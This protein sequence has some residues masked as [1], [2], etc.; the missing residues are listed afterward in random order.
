MSELA[1]FDPAGAAGPVSPA[2]AAIREAGATGSPAWIAFGPPVVEPQGWKLYVSATLLNFRPILAAVAPLFEEAGIPYKHVAGDKALRKLN[3]GLNGYSQVGKCIVAY[4]GEAE[5]VERLIAR[6]KTALEPWRDSCPDVPFARSLGGGLPL[7]YRYG[8]YRGG[9]IRVGG[10]RRADRRDGEAVPKG[11]PDP[12]ARFA[13]ADRSDEAFERFLARFPIFEAIAQG[14]KGGV[15][16]AF[17]LS[18][19]SFTEVIVKIG[20]R[21]GQVMPDGRDGAD[22]LRREHGFFMAL[23]NAGLGALAPACVAYG[24]FDRKHALVMERLPGEDLMAL[25]RRGELQPGHV[26]QCLDLLRRMHGAGL[27]AGDPKLANFVLDGGGRPRGIDFECA[28]LI[29][30]H[31]FDPLRTFRLFNPEIDDLRTLDL[32]HFLFSV[33]Y[34]SRAAASFSERDR[35]VDVAAVLARRPPEDPAAAFAL[36]EFKAL[37]S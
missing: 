24:E 28:G 1:E 35:L 7:F 22:L 18:R 19:D 33:L 23:E 21:N 8:A 6:L 2:S 36:A 4:L 37:L 16:A 12:L 9:R 31:V 30:D 26:A 11:V 5:G 32:A 3:A 13:S 34:D 10:R 27:Y 20:Y 25:R 14:G 17:D 29:A 15:F